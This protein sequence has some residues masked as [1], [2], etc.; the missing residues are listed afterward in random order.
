MRAPVEIRD[1]LE[2]ITAQT[3]SNTVVLHRPEGK[4]NPHHFV[5]GHDYLSLRGTFADGLIAL[6]GRWR[7]R[8]LRAS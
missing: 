2:T 4:T 6:I 1:Q 7:G 8:A 3:S 5:E